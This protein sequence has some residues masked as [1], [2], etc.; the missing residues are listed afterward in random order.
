VLIYPDQCKPEYSNPQILKFLDLSSSS[1]TQLFRLVVALNIHNGT[2]I[3]K[4]VLGVKY[5]P[6][7]KTAT[8]GP[9]P[10]HTR[11]NSCRLDSNRRRRPSQRSRTEPSSQLP[12][13]RGK[14][15]IPQ[16][17]IQTYSPTSSGDIQSHL[18]PQESNPTLKTST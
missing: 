17:I 4:Q 14:Y 8:A 5:Q 10:I 9:Y 18:A 6:V 1:K 15:P 16:P 7:S 11:P 2:Q 12:S 13:S 3:P